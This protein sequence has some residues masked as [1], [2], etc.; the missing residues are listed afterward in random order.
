ML[1]LVPTFTN[2]LVSAYSLTL[3]Y[4]DSLLGGGWIKNAV[5]EEDRTCKYTRV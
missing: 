4:T 5:I 2:I 1:T 3:P